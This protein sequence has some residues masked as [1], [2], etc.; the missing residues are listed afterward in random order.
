MK[1]SVLL[2]VVTCFLA[3]RFLHLPGSQPVPLQGAQQDHPPV[4]RAGRLLSE[5]GRSGLQRENEQ[6]TLQQQQQQTPLTLEDNGVE[7]QGQGEGDG[8]S[9]DQEEEGGQQGAADGVVA[10]PPP[11]LGFESVVKTTGLLKGLPPLQPAATGHDAYSLQP[12]QQLSMHPRLF[13]WPK[14]MSEEQAQHIVDLASALLAPSALALNDEDK[15]ENH[16]GVRTSQGTFVSRDDDPVL[17]WVEDKIESISGIPR[18]HGEAFNVLRYKLGQQYQQHYDYFPE[19]MY[20]KQPGGGN[21]MAT[22]LVYLSS[23]EEGGETIFPAEGPHGLDLLNNGTIDYSRCDLG[24]KYR[25]RAGDALLFYSM[26]PSCEL[27]QHSLHGGCPVVRG[28]KWVMTKWMWNRPYS[29]FGD[30][31]DGGDS[32]EGGEEE[33]VQE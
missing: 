18:S 13:L 26:T 28:T 5:G 27:D 1:A 9:L 15:E 33:H 29:D 22:V 14:F 17:A 32:G 24:F 16:E 12:V 31:G 25:P 30:G 7:G 3:G 19:D 6:L 4:L 21:R 20:G 10:P 2:A 11:P 8:G 23:V